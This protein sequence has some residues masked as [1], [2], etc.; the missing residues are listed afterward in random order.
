M[1]YEAVELLEQEAAE[2]GRRRLFIWSALLALGWVIYELTAQPNLGVVI[3]CAKFGWNDARTAWWLRRRDPN[4]ARGWACFWFYLASGLWKMAITAVIATFAVGFLA[5]ILEQGLA[6]GRQGRPN[7]QPMPPWLLGACLT[8]LFGFLLSSLATLLALWMAWRHRVRFWLSSSV[9]GY[10]RRDAWP[11]YQIDWIPANQGGRL[12]LTAVI[13]I[14]TPIIVTLSILLG[15]ALVHV[16][17]PAGIAVCTLALMVVVP[18]LLL[19][20]REALK[21]RFIAT[22]PW[23]CWSKEEAEDAYALENAF[24]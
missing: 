14:A 22:V 20:L 23:Q 15:A 10:R 24:E 5:G 8:A 6:N 21:R 16:F 19:S 7:P 4:G 18:M 11:P 1:D 17:G 13:V 12:L 9:H 2:R 3:V